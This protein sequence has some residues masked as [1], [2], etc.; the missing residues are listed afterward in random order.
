MNRERVELHYRDLCDPT[1]LGLG[2]ITY[3]PLNNGT[4]AEE[5]TVHHTILVLIRIGLLT[6]KYREGIPSDSRL[7]TEEF[8][9]LLSYMTESEQGKMSTRTR[10]FIVRSY[11]VNSNSVYR[12]LYW[13]LLH[14]KTDISYYRSCVMV[15]GTSSD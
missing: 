12:S 4:E 3:S 13:V 14:T 15:R 5:L 11:L 10:T 9:S 1:R 8:Q 7:A 2:M 6:G